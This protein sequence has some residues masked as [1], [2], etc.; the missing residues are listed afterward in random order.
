MAM[1]FI[2]AD[3]PV[4][5]DKV[6]MLATPAHMLQK[7]HW[8]IAQLK[9]M[10]REKPEKLGYVHAPSYCAFN[11]AVTAWHIA[12][13]VWQSPHAHHEDLLSRFG[14]AVTVD[15]KRNFSAFQNGIRQKSRAIHI[16]RQLATGSK[17]MTVS[18][19]ADPTVKADMRFE[20]KSATFGEAK[21]GDPFAVSL[22][23]LIVTDNEEERS[24]VDVFEQAYK[25]WQRFLGEWGFVEGS[26]Y[27]QGKPLGTI[28]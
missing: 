26:A 9:K 11:C 2:P 22:Y 25:D 13:W 17:H 14:L 16:C 23:H 6:F 4:S 18:N 21:Y 12:D 5:P 15:D 10:L 24:A 7:F 1:T 27:V 3:V 19:H 8:E 20:T 28:K